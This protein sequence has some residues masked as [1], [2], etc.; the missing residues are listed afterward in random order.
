[1]TSNPFTANLMFKWNNNQLYSTKNNKLRPVRAVVSN[2]SL[3]Q[4]QI[5]MKAPMSKAMRKYSLDQLTLNFTPK[6]PEEFTI[7]IVPCFDLEI[8]SDTN[9]S[10]ISDEWVDGTI[11]EKSPDTMLR[12]LMPQHAISFRKLYGSHHLRSKSLNKMPG[13][14][15]GN[16]AKKNDVDSVISADTLSKETFS[17]R[18]KI[19]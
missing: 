7:K 18:T 17:Y 13:N 1:M 10:K 15:T 4:P 8:E 5:Q 14:E 2:I 12:K 11:N 19:A 6:R 3:I 16:Y 9:I